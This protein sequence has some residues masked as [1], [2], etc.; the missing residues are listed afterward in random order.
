VTRFKGTEKNLRQV[1]EELG[2]QYVLEGSVRKAGNRVRIVA[3]L[4]DANTGFELWSDDFNADLKDIFGVQEQTAL[5]IAEALDLRLSP[6]EQRA[7]ERGYTDSPEAFDAF[8]RGRALVE[9]FSSAEKLSAARENFERALELDP[10]YPL[11]LVGL[12]RVETQFHRNIDPDPKRL[13]RAEELIQRALAE[14]PD[15]AEAHV[16]IGELHGNR[17]DYEH[18]V[19]SF[20]EALRIDPDHAHAWDLL[21]W[22]LAYLQPPKAEEAEEAARKAIRLQP[23]LIGAYYHLGRALLLQGRHDEA[24]DAFQ[25]ARQLDH[26]FQSAI[27]GIGQVY[28]EQDKPDKALEEFKKLTSN[29]GSPVIQAAVAS[30]H[31]A[32]GDHDSALRHLERALQA[33]YRDFAALQANRHLQVLRSDPRYAALI[34]RYAE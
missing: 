22:A 26:G 28:L 32:Q 11:A 33:G 10:N 5:K 18:A 7:I 8:L 3:Q 14:E 24:I 27:Y 29:L 1:G 6:Q 21:S 16:A 12:S 13:E 17:F 4:V 31:S 34:E 2:V 19:E 9:F 30:A 25:Q 20:R 23:P 15:F